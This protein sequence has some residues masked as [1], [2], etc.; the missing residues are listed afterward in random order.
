MTDL[1]SSI[2]G[3]GCLFAVNIDTGWTLGLSALYK[4]F[5][6]SQ[7]IDWL[8]LHADDHAF[9]VLVY[10]LHPGIAETNITSFLA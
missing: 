6:H 8:N 5:K 10:V 4:E 2:V 9:Y 7:H 3:Q 1:I